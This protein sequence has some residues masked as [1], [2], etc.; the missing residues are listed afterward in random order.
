M[1]KGETRS[2]T[3][4]LSLLIVLM[5]V[6]LIVGAT[7][8]LFTS[9]DQH[10]ISVQ[11][12]EVNVTG[13][14]TIGKVS[15]YD[16]DGG[17]NNETVFE[18]GTTDAKLLNGG[19]ASVDDNGNVSIQGIAQGET[20]SLNLEIVN[21]SSIDIRY[22]VTLETQDAQLFEIFEF[23]YNGQS[24][25]KN[26]DSIV[27]EK[28]MPLSVGENANVNGIE[29]SMPWL[30]EEVDAD[31]T[32][33]LTG[34]FTLT[35]R[36]VQYNAVESTGDEE[37]ATA[38]LVDEN[39]NRTAF[40]S[41]QEALAAANAS[42]SPVTL[43]LFSG[44]YQSSDLLN[45]QDGVSIKGSGAGATIIE[46]TSAISNQ[47]GMYVRGSG[48]TIE[49]I[50]V[51]SEIGDGNVSALKVGGDAAQNIVIK[52][53]T[54][55]ANGE[56]SA[57]NIHNADNVTVSNVTLEN[58]GKVG[59][60]IAAADG[61]TIEGVNFAEATDASGDAVWGDIGLMWK[62]DD[63]YDEPI[64]NV[65]LGAGNVFA[66]NKIYSDDI[67]GASYSEYEG[68]NTGYAKISGYEQY[69]LAAITSADTAY[70]PENDEAGWILVEAN[71][72]MTIGSGETA[73]YETF[74]DIA[75][76]FN[77]VN[78]NSSSEELTLEISEG[79][80]DL[81]A[82]DLRI[83]RDNVTVKGAGR[84]ETVLNI[85]TSGDQAS[86]AVI[87]SNV[88]ISDLTFNVS[89]STKVSLMKISGQ[90]DSAADPD[91]ANVSIENVTLKGTGEYTG[92]HAIDVNGAHN[93][94]LD[95]VILENYTGRGIQLRN[96]DGGDYA[97]TVSNT[98]FNGTPTLGW[99]IGRDIGYEYGDGDSGNGL[100][101]LGE[102]N[103][104]NSAAPLAGYDY[105]IG[106][107]ISQQEIPVPQGWEEYGFVLTENE[108]GTW[109]LG[110]ASSSYAA[111]IGGKVT[112]S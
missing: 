9:S 18:N 90:Y 66:L 53:V 103:E 12:G 89:N 100:I 51:R 5:C 59:I 95:G 26:A 72:K 83:T 82:Y 96:T 42:D 74:M 62:N 27:Y 25:D 3:I 29:I 41:L 39:G 70:W 78:T 34:E 28:W 55:E 52:D 13:N 23:T 4:I 88:T 49:G 11:T 81:T 99:S 44:V 56:A 94:T 85:S 67:T 101:I 109:L 7:L 93:V 106:T 104:F 64:S 58:Y 32:G 97:V 77:A 69:G 43:N 71:A 22:L 91:L 87:A 48:V 105:P 30:T 54:I 38:T 79:Q 36:A 40:T 84:D 33:P 20:V 86:V 19:S 16:Q 14:L 15:S 2:K 47:A 17:N 60:A 6:S 46:T 92:K 76:A 63:D 75:G 111:E 112:I 50:T 98:S 10:N 35:L 1:Q 80:Y 110:A 73:T 21:E 31:I 57:L 108:N 107:A 45:V 102:G 24:I 37:L 65:T 68:Y 8:A 61:V